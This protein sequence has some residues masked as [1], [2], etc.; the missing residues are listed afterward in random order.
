MIPVLAIDDEPL[1]LQQLE[2][3]I[4]QVPYLELVGSCSHVREAEKILAE[5]PVGAVFLD[6][7]MPECSGLD[8]VR[9]LDKAPLVVFTTA[10]SRYAVEGFRVNAVDYLLKPF[11]FKEFSEAAEK[12]RVRYG[13]ARQEASAA[14]P[15]PAGETSQAVFFRTERRSVRVLLDD[16]RYIEGMGEYAK[17]HRR[18]DPS[19]LLVL[20]RLKQLEEKLPAGCFLRIHRS[21]IIPVKKLKEAGKDEVLLED[22]TALP[23]GEHYHQDLKAYLGKRM[24]G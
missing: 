12:V 24:L 18:D 9:E 16:I 20:V 22:G 10:Y 4:A 11:S 23:I 7:N 15:K 6:I 14:A 3:Y 19:P 2:R 13:Q 5:R 17:I 21:Y 1:A 8:W